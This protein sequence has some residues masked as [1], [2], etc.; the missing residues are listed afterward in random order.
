M[1]MVVVAATLAVGS[2]TLAAVADAIAQPSTEVRVGP[3]GKPVRITKDGK[4]TTCVRDGVKMGYSSAAAA[5]Y[6]GR[7][8]LR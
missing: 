5:D 2:L 4:Y 3:N 1:R 8:G 7:R 6:C